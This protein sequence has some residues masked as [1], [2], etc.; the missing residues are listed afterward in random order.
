MPDE[1]S[2]RLGLL[3]SF[4]A[5][6][7]AAS[8]RYAAETVI[9]LL[10]LSATEGVGLLMLV[11][12]LQLVGV[13]TRQGNLGG[14]VPW[15]G[16]AFSAVGLQ[17]TLGVVLIVYVVLVAVQGL[18]QR[19]QTIVGALLERQ[20]VSGLRPRLYQAIAGT[21][22]VVF[23]RG[24]ISDYAEVLTKEVDRV[25][26]VT[27]ALMDLAVLAIIALVYIALAVRIS[28]TMT[29]IVLGT[30]GLVALTMRG[31]MRQASTAGHRYSQASAQLY[32]AIT[33]H[34]TGMKIARSY[35]VEARHAEQFAQV[36]SHVD[37]V[38]L[39][40]TRA[41]AGFRQWLGLATAGFLAVIVYVSHSVL[42]IA[43][44][45]LLLLLFL[46]ARLVPRL[47]T[48]YE[49]TQFIA[50]LLPAFDTIT[51]LERRCL[52]A[53]EPPATSQRSITL[54]RQVAFDRV[55]FDYRGDGTVLA[56]RDVAL[57]IASGKTTA[58]VGP[59]GSGKSTMADI[60]IGLL[61]PTAGRLLIDGKPLTR[62]DMRS[63]REQI[64]YVPQEPFLFHDTIRA[65]LLWA[66]PGATE[67]ELWDALR[68][69][70][71]EG[72]VQSLPQ[73]LDT[74][75]GDRGVLVS[76]GERQRLALARALLRRP[77]ILI[78][79]EAT[80][81]LDAANE[82]RI[83]RAIDDLHE[84]MTIVVV[85]HRLSMIRHADTIHVIDKGT[86]IESGTWDELMSRPFSRLAD[87][88]RGQVFPDETQ[89]APLPS[90][91]QR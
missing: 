77:A 3:R 80:S 31:A 65:N 82:I 5:R 90:V 29:G 83:Q 50:S 73:G 19:R 64:G 13:D 57:S 2:N 51:S 76:G 24:R 8:P 10:A 40:I 66:R 33:E 55:S 9:L 26:M 60:L 25:S 56:L 81:S 53:A 17:P 84:Q 4:S 71:A 21:R 87:F 85:T 45:Q 27:Y 42:A 37:G 49:K 63:W 74:V 36:S 16:R 52:D 46:F 39:A 59:S 6:L 69:G 68:L 1:S 34:L 89:A 75:V 58:I 61:E 35:G 88:A 11:P 62:D 41:Q 18:I 47:S 86:L 7:I 78:L 23:S 67:S 38:N 91:A 15:F 32:S 48:I 44:A 43:T 70:A 28:P 30:A 14:V 12:L 79:D 72:F 20:F 54:G 22:W